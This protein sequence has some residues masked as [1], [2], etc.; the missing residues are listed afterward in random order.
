MQVGNT[1]ITVRIGNPLPQR[2]SILSA[3][4]RSVTDNLKWMHWQTADPLPVTLSE[5]K[6]ASDVTRRARVSRTGVRINFV[7]STK[8]PIKEREAFGVIAASFTTKGLR[9]NG[10][11]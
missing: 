3:L 10:S 4:S 8:N 7:K 2:A 5:L 11:N 6:S 9:A 1:G